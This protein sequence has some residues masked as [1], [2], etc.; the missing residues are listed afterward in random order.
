MKRAERGDS[1]RERDDKKGG[2]D[3]KNQRAKDREEERAGATTST[4]F[5][6]EHTSV[7]SAN[8]PLETKT[9]L[10][11]QVGFYAKNRRSS[12]EDV[13][14]R[15]RNLTSSDFKVERSADNIVR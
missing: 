10:F 14:T 5:S 8:H 15:Q 12:R 1:G 6:S 9:A 11:R 4:S 7:L 13:I 3:E 2:E